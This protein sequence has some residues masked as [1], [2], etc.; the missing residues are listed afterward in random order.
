M[1]TRRFALRPAAVSLRCA[2][3]NSP[4]PI[5]ERRAGCDAARSR[6]G[7]RR[8]RR[9]R[10]T[11]PS[12][13]GNS[14]VLIGRLSVWPSTRTGFGYLTSVVGQRIERRHRARSDSVA[15]PLGNRMS[16][17]IFDFEPELVAAHGDHVRVHQRLQRASRFRRRRGS[18][19][20]RHRWLC[21]RRLRGV[22]FGRPWLLVDRDRLEQLARLSV[23][24]VAC[25]TID[26]GDVGARAARLLAD[27]HRL[28]RFRRAAERGRAA[29]PTAR[30][31]CPR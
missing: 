4:N 2:G 30:G 21:R 12:S 25:C 11:A 18:S 13:R 6:S 9:A 27:L 29:N 19:C 26:D 1:T 14:D 5:T 22:G 24:G 10:P 16:V 28:E 17:R 8:S 3:R 23:D 20:W 15:T 7:A 31:T